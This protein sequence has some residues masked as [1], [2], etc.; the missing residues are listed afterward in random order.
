MMAP[1][2]ILNIDKNTLLINGKFFSQPITGVQRFAREI[3]IE[4]DNHI[5]ALSQNPPVILIPNNSTDI[6]NFKNLKLIYTGMNA[7]H[8]WEQ[9]YLPFISRGY[10]I[11]NLSGSAPLF[12]LNQFVTMH[13]AAV[14]EANSAYSSIFVL[15]YKFLFTLQAR[16]SKKVFTVSVFSKKRLI[17]ALPALKNKISI[18]PNGHEHILKMKS[19]QDFLQKHRLKFK[20]YYFILGSFNPNKNIKIILDVA[21]NLENSNALFVITGGVNSE[22][23]A[24]IHNSTSTLRNVRYVG[25]VDDSS[26]KT[27]YLNA[28]CFIFPSVYEGFGIPILEALALGTDVIASDIPAIREVGGDLISY[29]QANEPNQLIK[30]IL[31]YENGK[32]KNN[33]PL[34]V[35]KCLAKFS[36][37][38]S[39]ELLSAALIEK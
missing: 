2:L 25:Q 30:L 1:K 12:K 38:K 33:N 36:W 13:D 3:L 4:L 29:Y 28:K 14:F 26:L 17:T 23:F 10:K 27:L 24:K 22:S 15:W 5:G 8:F 31:D 32:N 9:L 34:E 37:K 20:S 21:K 19:N 18:I 16:L 6:P 11:F 39:S 7:S 35:K